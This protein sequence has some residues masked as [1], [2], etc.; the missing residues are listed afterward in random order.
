MNEI[1]LSFIYAQLEKNDP[2]VQAAYEWIIKHYT[3]EENPG[4][5]MQGLYYNYHT[6][7]KALAIFG[8]EKI[9]VKGRTESV[10]WRKE[11]LEKLIEIQKGDGYWVNENGRW[12]ESDPVLVTAYAA[13]AMEIAL[14]GY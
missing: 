9:P 14:S 1:L 3:L 5:G 12:W 4:L 6:M 13:L 11:L 10:E 8:E 7:A 2:R